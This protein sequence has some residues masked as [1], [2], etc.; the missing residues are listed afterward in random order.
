MAPE[1]GGSIEDL[2]PSTRPMDFEL[3]E[4][5][6]AFADAVSRFAKAT[7]SDGALAR[8]HSPHYPW[9]TAKRLSAQGLL[10]I[11]I[12]E[13]DGGVGGTLMDAVI[14]IQQVALVCPKS[15]DIVQAGRIRYCTCSQFQIQSALDPGPAPVGG[16]QGSR[17][18]KQMT[19]PMPSQ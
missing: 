9:D 18:L 19:S 16:S 1:V 4:E 5:Q 11:T 6:R 17:T 2:S 15:A 8:A 14:A 12:P 10:G 7:L 13:A 3:T